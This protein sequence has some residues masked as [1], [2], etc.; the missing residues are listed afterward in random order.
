MHT[1]WTSSCKDSLQAVSFSDGSV[2]HSQVARTDK[3]DD[4]DLLDV[5]DPFNLCT[6]ES[7]YKLIGLL[8][9]DRFFS[10]TINRRPVIAEIFQ[11][12]PKTHSLKRNDQL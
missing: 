11:K 7:R 1:V 5:L 9:G 4:I 10:I 2:L 3:I 6:P 8:P 12:R